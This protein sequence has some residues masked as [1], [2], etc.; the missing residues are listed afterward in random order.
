[1]TGDAKSEREEERGA[2]NFPNSK[3]QRS[4]QIKAGL[5]PALEWT[6]C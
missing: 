4:L 6:P 5:D 1:M 2:D 3:I